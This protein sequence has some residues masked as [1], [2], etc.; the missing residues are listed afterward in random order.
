MLKLRSYQVEAI[1]MIRCQIYIANMSSPPPN[2]TPLRASAHIFAAAAGYDGWA[3][4]V[5]E[6]REA[7]RGVPAWDVFVCAPARAR[8]KRIGTMIGRA[9]DAFGPYK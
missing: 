4:K 5:R 6:S 1:A 2:F 3:V 7:P 8:G 9:C